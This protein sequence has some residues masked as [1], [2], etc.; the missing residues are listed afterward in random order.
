MNLDNCV[1]YIA[2]GKMVQNDITV[3]EL[4]QMD[5]NTKHDNAKNELLRRGDIT[6]NRRNYVQGSK[7]ASK[8]KTLC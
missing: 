6:S 3:R 7:K 2:Q 4:L 8:I 5:D 1:N